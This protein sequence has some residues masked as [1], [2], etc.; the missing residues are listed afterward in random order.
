MSVL[1]AAARQTDGIV[2]AQFGGGAVAMGTNTWSTAMENMEHQR[3]ESH[4]HNAVRTNRHNTVRTNNQTHT[5]REIDADRQRKQGQTQVQ[6]YMGFIL[7]LNTLNSLDKY[8]MCIL[9]DTCT[10]KIL[11]LHKCVHN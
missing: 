7:P 10:H 2:A 4:R 9:L 8:G 6:T 11:K 3:L 1:Y 5:E